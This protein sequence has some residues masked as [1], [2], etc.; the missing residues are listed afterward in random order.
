MCWLTHI[1]CF[2]VI[3]A[4][5]CWAWVELGVNFADGSRAIVGVELWGQ[6]RGAVS[7]FW[8]LGFGKG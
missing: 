5:D 8:F 7:L 6:R 1:V 4:L 2:V 3:S